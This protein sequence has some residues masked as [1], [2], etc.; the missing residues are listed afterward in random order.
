MCSS[1]KTKRP[2]AVVMAPLQS[3]TFITSGSQPLCLGDGFGPLTLMGYRGTRWR[4]EPSRSPGPGRGPGRGSGPQPGGCRSHPLLV[5][6]QVSN[7]GRLALKD[8]ELQSQLGP[9]PHWMG[10]DTNA[11]Q[12]LDPGEVWTYMALQQAQL[13]HTSITMDL[14]AKAS[15]TDGE[16]LGLP[17]LQRQRIDPLPGGPPPLRREI[18]PGCSVIPSRSPS[19]MWPPTRS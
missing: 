6:M 3:S 5:T 19:A 18:S 13:G 9:A 8:I 11:N 2:I 15:D 1:T 14:R 7:P 10:G 4:K 16:D 12:L 17:A